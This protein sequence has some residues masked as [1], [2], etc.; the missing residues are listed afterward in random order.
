[1]SD[2]RLP[3][4]ESELSRR[5]VFLYNLHLVSRNVKNTASFENE[6][7]NLFDFPL[8]YLPELKDLKEGLVAGEDLYSLLQNKAYTPRAVAGLALASVAGRRSEG[9]LVASETIRDDRVNYLMQEAR[10]YNNMA[11]GI[12]N[13]PNVPAN[14]T[15]E[16][17]EKAFVNFTGG[18][19]I[20]ELLRLSSESAQEPLKEAL[21]HSGVMIREGRGIYAAMIQRRDAF[22][23]FVAEKTKEGEENGSLYF[24][25]TDV[26]RAKRNEAKTLLDL[27]PVRDL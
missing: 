8:D 15:P 23:R 16:D 5:A 18:V 6:L 22:D 27:I 10:V 12:G 13:T 14:A 3:E 26:A 11:E 4:F 25:W 20:L 19:P 24:A 21:G 7:G 2:T 1:M 17:I 9:I